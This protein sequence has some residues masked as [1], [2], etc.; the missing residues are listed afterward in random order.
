M[1]YRITEQKLL[2]KPKSIN[3]DVALEKQIDMLK[4]QTRLTAL[5]QA[6]NAKY[7]TEIFYK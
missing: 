7:K 1:L 2:F 5:V 4:E 3:A 6:L